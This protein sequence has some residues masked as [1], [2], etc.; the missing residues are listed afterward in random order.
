MCLV[1]S[2]IYIY[3]CFGKSD[4]ILEFFIM[5]TL[6]L[7]TSP[8]ILLMA[9]HS[10]IFMLFSL[11]TTR[12]E[13]QDCFETHCYSLL[14]INISLHFLVG[15]LLWTYSWFSNY[16]FRV[17]QVQAFSA[18]SLILKNW[19]TLRATPKTCHFR[20]LLQLLW[21][22][23]FSLQIHMCSDAM[24]SWQSWAD[25][26]MS[27]WCSYSDFLI[28]SLVASTSHL[29]NKQPWEETFRIKFSVKHWC[30][31]KKYSCLHF[32]SKIL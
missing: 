4:W 21:Y 30:Q 11:Q 31:R 12:L 10:N 8:Y 9:L 14:K 6:L 2:I 32:F 7:L 13:I 27:L 17:S 5:T 24:I 15:D 1:N 20:F 18:C 22:R 3:V 16:S 19:S 25:A 28:L 26:K 23:T 29:C